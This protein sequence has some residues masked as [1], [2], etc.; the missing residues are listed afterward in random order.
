MHVNGAFEKGKRHLVTRN[1]LCDWPAFILRLVR[2]TSGVLF[3]CFCSNELFQ[4]Y[5]MNLSKENNVFIFYIKLLAVASAIQVL[6]MWK[7]IISCM[8]VTGY[9]WQFSFTV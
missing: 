3:M 8:T 6:E 9:L 5:D 7:S 4:Y 1:Q 2:L